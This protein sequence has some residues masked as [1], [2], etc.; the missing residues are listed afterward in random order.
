MP[1]YLPS[2]K[3]NGAEYVWTRYLAPEYLE[4]GQI[5][6]KVDVYAFG[7]IL[8]ELMTGKRIDELQYIERQQFLSEWFHP[9]ATLEPGHVIANNY[10]LL[11]PCLACEP[12]FDFPHQ[13]EAM[14]RA[15]SLC[16]R[17]D[18][19]SRPPMSKVSCLSLLI[20]I[21]IP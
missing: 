14:C 18:P 20:P 2:K 21:L 3:I 16:L 6:N 9:L 15:A 11:D 17:R 19:E 10:H 5:T 1:N 4:G 12:S 8:L 13:L 7:V